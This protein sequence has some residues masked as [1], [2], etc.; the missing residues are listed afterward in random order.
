MKK[1][2]VLLSILFI[3]S[4]TSYSQQV[5]SMESIK[6]LEKKATKVVKE[7]NTLIEVSKYQQKSTIQILA[8]VA[9]EYQEIENSNKGAS[10][11]TK[12]FEDLEKKKEYGLRG[13]LNNQQYEML[14]SILEKD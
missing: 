5:N 8:K 2:F 1:I 6:T 7:L 9:Q 3:V 10:E 12:N 13:V 14:L 4:F 11:K